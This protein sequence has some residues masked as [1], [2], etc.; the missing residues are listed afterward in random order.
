MGLNLKRAAE[1]SVRSLGRRKTGSVKGANDLTEV[2]SQNEYLMVC[3]FN[4]FVL[5]ERERE[6]AR[7]RQERAA[8]KSEG[9]ERSRED[10]PKGGADDKQ[11]NEG[12]SEQ[13]S[14]FLAS[15][16]ASCISFVNSAT[17]YED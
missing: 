3:A 14:N 12:Y 16:V 15:E 2:F 9:K 8:R 17:G 10:T 4:C 13:G 6:K 5:R 11:V 7:E 1:I